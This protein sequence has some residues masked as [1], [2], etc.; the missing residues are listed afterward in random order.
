MLLSL[1]TIIPLSISFIIV[2]LSDNLLIFTTFS[3]I[4]SLPISFEIVSLSNDLLIYAPFSI[5]NCF[6][7]DLF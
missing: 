1:S 5:C 2:S 6:S 3:T 4:V 7:S